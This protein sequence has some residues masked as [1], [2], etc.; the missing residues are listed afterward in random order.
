MRRPIA[1][2]SALLGLF[3][4]GCGKQT[5]QNSS[6]L[7][8]ERPSDLR[9]GEV[10]TTVSLN[11]YEWRKDMRCYV[12]E[13][14]FDPERAFLPEPEALKW[15]EPHRFSGFLDAT[16][17]GSTFVAARNGEN[18]DTMDRNRFQAQVYYDDKRISLG[19]KLVESYW[20]EFVGREALCNSQRTSD[21]DFQATSS[22][23]LV[24][25]DRF[26]V[27]RRIRRK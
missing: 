14:A 18:P 11:P 12:S 19:S 2:L 5:P 4:V 6:A 1:F 21:S 3:L 9:P 25:A 27:I 17:E 8:Q 22:P 10:M 16:F 26:E 23:N 13:E 20:V 24:I 15:R 7:A